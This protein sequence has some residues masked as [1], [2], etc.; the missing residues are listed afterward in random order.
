[1]TSA[2][3]GCEGR[4]RASQDE[5]TDV[6]WHEGERAAVGWVW[7]VPSDGKS[8]ESIGFE[9]EIKNAPEVALTLRFLCDTKRGQGGWHVDESCPVPKTEVRAQRAQQSFPDARSA[10]TLCTN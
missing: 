9:G 6:L 2:V 10:D 3:G 1:M 5:Q 4:C 7:A 8:W